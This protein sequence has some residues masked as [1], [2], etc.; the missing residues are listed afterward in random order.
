MGSPGMEGVGR[1]QYDVLSFDSAGGV[2][3]YA[4]R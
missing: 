2:T 4:S 1:D 3:T